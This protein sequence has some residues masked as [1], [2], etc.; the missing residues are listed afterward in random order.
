MNASHE[1]LKTF[2]PHEL[3]PAQ[4]RDLITGRAATVDEI[5]PLRA[6]LSPFIVARVVE[7]AR[8]PDSDRLSVTRVDAGGGELL[9][10][11][12]GAPNVAAGKLYPFA[13]V[14]T[15]MPGGLT[16]AKRKIRG[17]VS[18]GM[19]CSARELG[20][21]ADADGILELSVDVPPGTPLLQ[22]LPLG[23]T[24][25]VID[26]M[27]NRPDLLSHL[28]VA[29]ELA[30]VTGLPLSLP[31][32]PAG[33]AD[34][35]AAN[36]QAIEGLAG[37]ITVRLEDPEGSPR[38]M[39]VTIRG[40][41]VGPSPDW[42]VR[43]IESVGGRAINNVVDATNYLLHEIG[44]PMHAFDLAKLGGGAVVVRRARH[45]E[46]LRT[47]DGVERTLTPAM[48]VIADGG[49][50]QAVAG[51]MGGAESE[52]GDA[53]TDIFLEVASFDPAST[54]ATRR[55]LGLS[56]DASYRFERG[57]DRELPPTALARA[58]RLITSIAG[59]RVEGAPIDLYP[60]P[61][62]RRSLR[63]RAA[64]VARVLGE[65]L[66]GTE[67][68]M[69]LR[70][71]GFVADV[72]PGT[73]MLM[74]GEEIN[75]MVPTW[76]VDIESEVDLIEEVAR[77]RGY[78]TFP[79][80]LRPYR[81]T[82][83][84][85]DPM[86]QQ[87]RR[88]RE[89]LVAAGLLETRPMP[90]VAGLE[91]DH[92]G[93]ANPIA[94]NEAHLRRTILETLVPRAE[95]NLSHMQ[96]DVRLFEI[97]HVF[98]PRAHQPGGPEERAGAAATLPREALRVGVLLMGAR[99]PAHFTE[100]TPPAFDPWDAKGLAERIVSAAFPGAEAE[101]EAGDGAELLWHI[102]LRA[103]HGTPAPRAVGDVRRVRLDAPA[104]A[105]QAFGIEVELAEIDNA[106]VAPRGRTA[107]EASTRRAS[108]GSTAGIS[109]RAD[110]TGRKPARG[111]SPARVI[112]GPTYAPLP[113]TPASEVDIA[114]V[115]PE[116]LA[117][118]LN[119]EVLRRDAGE[120]LE[121][122]QLLDEYR[123]PH[124]PA[125]HRSLMW[126]LIFRHPERTLRDKEVEGRRE[127]LL[128]T[129]EKELGVRQRTT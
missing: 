7:A 46:K 72:S 81:P 40:V 119:E 60:A 50:A 23:D 92:V 110:A 1:W 112:I 91:G 41:R 47:L 82:T 122:V 93:I 25:M 36:R 78:D 114:L 121:R 52:V 35:P 109:V 3:T 44:Q 129:L 115:V 20:L 102:R 38:Y 84:P 99:R 39:G 64:R 71:I 29:R 97:G 126:R 42:L 111:G 70:S 75:V 9:D 108:G 32:L 14:G 83:V 49:R 86:W 27:P 69:P 67:I 103:A 6:D 51:V 128:K 58:V 63:L 57:V 19:L 113:T 18:A 62:E 77:L 28:G 2:V 10:V 116:S 96:G 66:S 100:R 45:A 105:A 98:E 37:P 54:R 88:V 125:G 74:A 127:K 24:R 106:D 107:Y 90:F 80:E 61:S 30:A 104:W 16:I 15:V 33:G 65:R 8:H 87:A 55:A 118:E 73:E 13:P 43:R 21:G 79:D 56:T 59:G 76:R 48:T 53:T 89:A 120:I 5:V 124:V 31:E 117:A 123:G 68:V 34:A 11:V 85:D 12:C 4:V 22:A 94:E 26:V 101:L 17:A 95:F